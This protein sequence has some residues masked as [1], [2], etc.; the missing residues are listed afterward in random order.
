[1]NEQIVAIGDDFTLS[2]IVSLPEQI[3][4]AKPAVVILNSGLMHRVGASRTSVGLARTL[5]ND[6]FLVLRFDLSG[7]GDSEARTD[8]LDPVDRIIQEVS[9]SLD[10]MQNQYGVHRF[11]L[12]GLCSGAQNAFKTALKDTRIV[13]LAGVD[14]FG[15][16]TRWFYVAH[17]AP[18]LLQPGH[19]KSFIVRNTKYLFSIFKRLVNKSGYEVEEDLWP[20]PPKEFVEQGYGQLVERGLKFL[21]IYTGSWAKQYNYLNQFYDMYPS[22]N[23]GQSVELKFKP[24]MTHT[25]QEPESQQFMIDTV[26]HWLTSTNWS[27]T[28]PAKT[29]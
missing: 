4:I 10:H 14:N 19:W 18:R 3:D 16:P 6:G 7:I 26:A 23:F 8:S 29:M 15:F 25:M 27:T 11:V 22:V 17:Y 28:A 1:M 5:A 24:K 12:Y 9:A 20:Y 2:G 13:G 21:Y